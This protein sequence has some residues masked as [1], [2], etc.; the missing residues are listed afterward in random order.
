M[1]RE[2]K[3]LKRVRELRKEMEDL[4]DYFDLLEARAV[5]LGKKR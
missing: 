3:V 2:Q 4:I 1:T 5:N